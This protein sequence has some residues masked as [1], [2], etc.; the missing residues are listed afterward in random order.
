MLRSSFRRPCGWFKLVFP[1]HAYIV[2]PFHLFYDRLGRKKST[3]AYMILG[4]IACVIVSL[5]PAGTNR[6]GKTNFAIYCFPPSFSAFQSK[7][8]SQ[9]GSFEFNSPIMRRS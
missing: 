6:T 9:F 1:A 2:Q 4:A 5:I 3:T 7:T 8:F